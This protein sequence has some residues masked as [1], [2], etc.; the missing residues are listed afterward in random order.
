MNLKKYKSDR[1]YTKIF[2]LNFS[3]ATFARLFCSNLKKKLL[4]SLNLFEA[5]NYNSFYRKSYHSNYVWSCTVKGKTC[6]VT[7]TRVKVAG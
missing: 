1:E 6:A 5:L 4:H 7:V 2:T 3:R